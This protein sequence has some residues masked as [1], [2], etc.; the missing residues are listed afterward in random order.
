MSL[1]IP[2]E[3][4]PRIPL[5]I[6]VGVTLGIP[7]GTLFAFNFETFFEVFFGWLFD[8]ILSRKRPPKWSQNGIKT[9]FGEKVKNS[10]SCR[11]ELWNQGF[12]GPGGFKNGSKK[13]VEKTTSFLMDFSSKMDPKW[14]QNASKNQW[15]KQWKNDWKSDAKM[16]PKG[17]QKGSQW[18]PKELT[19]TT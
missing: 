4:L 14:L 6:I 16:M 13:Q 5:G 9:G 17:S 10:T 2:V 11:R 15:K 19:K 12:G 18:D 8:S 1:N 3:I 7:F